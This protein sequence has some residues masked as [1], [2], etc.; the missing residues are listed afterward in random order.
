MEMTVLEICNAK[1]NKPLKW[2][3]CQRGTSASTSFAPRRHSRLN[4]E[5]PVLRDILLKS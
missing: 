2:A 3:T 1:L 5:R 4:S